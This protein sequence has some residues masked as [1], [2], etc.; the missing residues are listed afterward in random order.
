MKKVIIALLISILI[1]GAFATLLYKTVAPFRD[2]VGA[3]LSNVPGS[4]GEH[5]SALPTSEET[6]AQ[7]LR[8]A[9][10]ILDISADRAIDKLNAIKSEDRAIYDRVVKA[11]LRADPNKTEKL[12]K[13]LRESA[14]EENALLGTLQKIDE[15]QDQLDKA[16][17]EFIMSLNRVSA[18]DEIKSMLDESPNAVQSVAA[19]LK[20]MPD[21]MV[22]DILKR[23]RPT[24][25]AAIYLEMPSKRV[26]DLKAMAEKSEI[27]EQELLQTATLLATK[28]PKKLAQTLGNEDVYSIEQLATIY[29]VFGAKFGGEVLSHVDDDEFV[30]KLANAIVDSQKLEGESDYFSDD[31]LKSLNIFREYDDNLGELVKIY[32]EVDERKVADIIK[33]LYWNSENVKTYTLKNGENVEISDKALAVDLLKS[34]SSKKIA[35]ILSYL[36]NSISTDISTKLALPDL[37]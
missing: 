16:R 35:T 12:L 22:V 9:A 33:R 37:D 24:D 10:Y 8:V 19:V 30:S 17:A 26:L 34:F 2:V 36:D 18:M 21:Q 1:I 15:E 4:I 13:S 32:N 14:F 6:E 3:L 5:F 7:V 27:G 23:L 20:H 28:S 11:M 25:V 31:L 29:Q